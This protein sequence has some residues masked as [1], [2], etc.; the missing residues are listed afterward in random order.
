M[1][2]PKGL[3]YRPSKQTLSIKSEFSQTLLCAFLFLLGLLNLFKI[4]S[5]FKK[6][7]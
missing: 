1:C 2:T 5:S 6:A 7:Y 3:V 4:K